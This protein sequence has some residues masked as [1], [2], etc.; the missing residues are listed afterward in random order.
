MQTRGILFIATGKQYIEAAI[1]AAES[2]RASNPGLGIAFYGD[3]QNHGY[4]LTANP[5][6][7]DVAYPVE[8]PHRRSK[9]DFL[10]KSPFERTLYLDTDT[11]VVDD[12]SSLFDVLDRFDI[13][14]THAMR[15]NSPERLV[16][17]RKQLPRAFPQFN[18][19]VLLYRNTPQVNAF[20][21]SWSHHFAEAGFNQDQMTLRELLWDSELRIAVLPPEYNVRYEKYLWFWSKSEATPKILHMEK[22]HTGNAWMAIKPP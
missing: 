6:P 15:R 4:N 18:G 7:F 10:S 11:R 17:W 21:E 2:V 13:G 12:I 1:K 22:F 14:V 3:W 16:T 5:A 8:K 9:V 19:G 20:F